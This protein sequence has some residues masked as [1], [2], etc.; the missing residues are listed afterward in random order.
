VA[1]PSGTSWNNAEAHAAM[2]ERRDAS[3][4]DAEWR[5]HVLCVRRLD[6]T[7]RGIMYDASGGD[8]NNIPREGCVI[9][10]H[11]MIPETPAYGNVQGVRFGTA[12]GP[13][14]R[15]AV[16]ETGH[17][18]GLYHNTADNCFMNTTDQIAENSLA[19]GSAAFPDNIQWSYNGEDAKRLR[20]MPDIYV[21]S[22]CSIQYRWAHRSASRSSS[23]TNRVVRCRRRHLWT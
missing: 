9:A 1:E 15:T 3:N 11:W 2:L 6:A 18:M 12:T 14:F 5:Y 7:E 23:R 10:S 22:A 16:H 17:A 19:A 8:S 13:Y 4:L 20:H 21:R